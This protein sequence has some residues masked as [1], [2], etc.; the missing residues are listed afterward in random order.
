M[1]IGTT[2]ENKEVKLN[3]AHLQW[4]MSIWRWEEKKYTYKM[5]RAGW[6]KF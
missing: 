3:T 1:K 6:I 2:T 4:E 5:D